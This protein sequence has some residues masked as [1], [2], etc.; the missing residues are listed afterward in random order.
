MINLNLSDRDIAEF[1]ADG[2]V[3]V[4]QIIDSTT[5]ERLRERFDR[6]FAGEYES[7]LMPDEVNWLAGRDDETKTRQ[8]C[9]GWKGDRYV[10]EVILDEAIG[11]ACATLAGWPGTRINQDN[12]FFKPPG[13]SSVGFHQDE[14][15]EDWVIPASMVS[16]WI[17]LDDTTIE[18]GT[19]EYVRG[20]HGWGR[21]PMID[22]FHGPNDPDKELREAA[23]RAGHE[24][25]DKVP[26]VVKAGDCA[27]H[28]G[29]TWHGSL[30]NRGGAP[31]RAIVAH[32]MSSE[33][34]FHGEQIG[35]I[36]SRYKRFGD[37]EM[38]ESF[39]PI[40]WRDDGYRSPFLHSYTQRKTAWG[41]AATT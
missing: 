6:L 24:V 41:G 34:R 5:I 18:G 17:A 26:L 37:D 30:V 35:P 19:I 33:A 4:E 23:A 28:A 40:L 12:L 21:S 2:F 38:D 27:L 25:L 39:F 15:Y 7:G 1:H 3:V 13:G 29:R 31:R 14:A 8:I 20:S 22:Q 9:N 10:A 16:C 32:C 11:R 36:Y